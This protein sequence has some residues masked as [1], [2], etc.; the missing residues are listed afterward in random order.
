MFSKTSNFS[1]IYLILFALITIFIKN[2]SIYYKLKYN[3]SNFA[4]IIERRREMGKKKDTKAFTRHIAENTEIDEI[5]YAVAM[6]ELHILCDHSKKH[7]WFA[8]CP[9]H[10]W[11]TVI[12]E[13]KSITGYS[14][15][16]D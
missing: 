4:P 5:K 8:K 9:D 12:S 10:L 13:I 1:I 3:N 2:T 7:F 6:G 15:L 16:G 14:P 11:D